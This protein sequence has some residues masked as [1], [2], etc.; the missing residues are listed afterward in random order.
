MTVKRLTPLPVFAA[1][2]IRSAV[3]PSSTNILVP[4]IVQPSPASVAVAVMPASSQSAVRL[5]EGE[6]GDG[7]AGGDAGEEVLLGRVVAGVESVLAASTT[8]EK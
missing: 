5:R 2:M 7:L 6:G 4:L 8:D 3:W 1:T